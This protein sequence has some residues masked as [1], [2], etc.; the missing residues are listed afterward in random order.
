LNHENSI[1]L[2]LTEENYLT[3]AIKAY[4]ERIPVT[5]SGD[6]VKEGGYC[7]V[8]NLRELGLMVELEET[9]EE[10]DLDLV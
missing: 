3:L 10:R 9:T 6:F 1:S 4:Q 8:K 7:V 5:C 2:E